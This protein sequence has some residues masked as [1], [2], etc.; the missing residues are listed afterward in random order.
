[1]TDA[2]S[3]TRGSSPARIEKLKTSGDKRE[4]DG[5]AAEDFHAQARGGRK[6]VA[7]AREHAGRRRNLGSSP[8]YHFQR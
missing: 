1:M 6:D 4:G 8:N 7:K 3:P 5:E 2:K